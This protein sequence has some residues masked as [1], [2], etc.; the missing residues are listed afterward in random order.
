MNADGPLVSV[1]VPCYR[2]D[3]YLPEA[4]ESVGA[5]TYSNW[6]IITVDDCCP[7][8]RTEEIVSSFAKNFERNHI[9]AIRHDENRGV[10]AARNTAIAAARGD[11]YAFLDPDDYWLPRYLS[12][13]VQFLKDHPQRDAVSGPVTLREEHSTNDH[14]DIYGPNQCERNWFPA[15]LSSRNF[16]Q[17]SSTIVRAQKVDLVEGFDEDPALQHVEDWDLWIRLL[18]AGVQF[19]ILDQPYCVYR[20][21]PEAATSDLQRMNQLIEI[22]MVRHQG[23]FIRMRG[24]LLHLMTNELTAR[25]TSPRPG[26]VMRVLGKLDR[27]FL[28]MYDRIFKGT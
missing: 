27:I 2:M 19:G 9:V 8:G 24:Q 13:S 1:I 6:E 21:H 23:W 7:N 12:E 17:P 11:L 14:S 22:L 20:K 10:S 26:P 18:I 3:K 15:S 16:L 28:R 25:A 4:L 5:Q